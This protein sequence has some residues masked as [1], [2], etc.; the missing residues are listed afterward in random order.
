MESIE[1][2]LSKCFQYFYDIRR[3]RSKYKTTK[4]SNCQKVLYIYYSFDISKFLVCI[5]L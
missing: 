1:H 4:I 3:F 2:F 5:N